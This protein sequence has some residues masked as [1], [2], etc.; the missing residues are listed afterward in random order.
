MERILLCQQATEVYILKL[1]NRDEQRS[2]AVLS[3]SPDVAGR[4]SKYLP[5]I[6]FVCLKYKGKM[7]IC[8]ERLLLCVVF[9]ILVFFANTNCVLTY[10]ICII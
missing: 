5:G 7:C 3:Y 1:L 6:V 8:K 10:Q 2:R 4:R 9:H